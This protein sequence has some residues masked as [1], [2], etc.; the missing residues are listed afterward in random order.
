MR[1]L[2]TTDTIGGVWTYTADLAE[3]LLERSCAVALVSFGRL[4]SPAQQ[5]WADAMT[6]RFGES[7]LY[8]ALERPLEWMPGYGDGYE[9]DAGLLIGMAREFGADLF[10]TNQ[11][12]FGSLPLGIPK[13]VVA[14]SDLR[15]WA[16]A[17]QTELQPKAWIDRYCSLVSEGLAAASAVVAPTAWML[18]T[19]RAN[20]VLPSRS[21]VI[22]NG[23]SLPPASLGIPR[24]LQAVTAGR[25]WDRAKNLELLTRVKAP[26]PILVAG[27]REPGTRRERLGSARL[28]GWL[29]PGKLFALLRESAIYICPSR[30]EPFGLAPL[31]AGLCGCAIV[32][33]DIGSL[34]ET[35]KGAALYFDDAASLSRLLRRLAESPR[36][37]LLARRRSQQR[38]GQF[39]AARMGQEYLAV[40]QSLVA[41][42]PGVACAA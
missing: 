1:V 26:F 33:N 13:L 42:G 27:E 19:L 39:S 36:D 31:E 41:A 35:W 3:A 32:A 37:L 10:H 17:C 2:M 40:Y 7:F 28:L 9:I 24:R 11:F 14:H 18:E 6:I 5:S 21:L 20:F 30:Y 4:P 8:R 12:C 15:S 22:P 25:L 38:A 34:H 16:A 29:E 23:R